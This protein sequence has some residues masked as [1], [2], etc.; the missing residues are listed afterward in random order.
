MDTHMLCK[1]FLVMSVNMHTM[2]NVWTRIKKNWRQVVYG[3][4]CIQ[5]IFVCN[6]LDED[7]EFFSVG[8][9]NL[10]DCSYHFYE[11]SNKMF[12]PF[13]RVTS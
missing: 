7:N 2:L 3:P 13:I 12:D 4:P 10:L 9:E 1:T 5:S 11:M 8:M 6:H